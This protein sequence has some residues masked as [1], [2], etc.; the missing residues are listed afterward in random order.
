MAVRGTEADPLAVA[1]IE[2]SGELK[3]QLVEFALGPRFEPELR[4]KLREVAGDDMTMDEATW[5]RTI[6]DFIFGYRF[7]D[8]TAMLDAFIRDN[9]DLLVAEREMLRGWGAH[10]DGIFELRRKHEGSLSVLNLID[11]LEY[12]V[13]TNA[14]TQAFGALREG[15]FLVG[16]L[17]PV[18]DCWLV[19]GML[20]SY[21]QASAQ[22]MAEVALEM[23][24]K[25]AHLAF[26]NPLIAERDGKP[27][28]GTATSSSGSSAVMRWSCRRPRRSG[29]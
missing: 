25:H 5:I 26:R 12:R 20:S 6:D 16:R 10:V 21:P 22:A 4:G 29:C 17:V 28:G 2:R 15:E 1:L 23:A 18:R 27:C 8:G 14:G 3:R 11:D 19:S 7:P 9:Q 13:Y 24:T